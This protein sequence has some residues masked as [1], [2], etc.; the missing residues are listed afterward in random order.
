VIRRTLVSA[1]VLAALLLPAA[2]AL[3]APGSDSFFEAAPLL[4]SVPGA[5]D[6]QGY[7]TQ[8]GLEPGASPG[9]PAM[10]HTAWWRIAGTGQQIAVSTFDSNFDTVLAAYDQGDGAPGVDNRVTCDDNDASGTGSSAIAFPS[11]R[12]RS[13]LV[14]VGG[15]DLAASG[16]IVLTASAT[17]PASDDAAGAQVLQTGVPATVSNLGASHELGE[18]LSCGADVYAATTWYRFTAP[19]V[20][21]AAFSASAAF[22]TAVAVYRADSG[23]SVGCAAGAAPRAAM[24]VSAGDYLVQVATKGADFPGL[25]EGPI[26]T[27]AQFT[28]DPDLDQDGVLAPA[29]CDD[30]NPAI[31]PGALEIAGDGIDQDCNGAD[32]VIDRDRDGS[33]VFKDCNDENAKIKPGAVEIVGNGIDENCDGVVRR[34]PRLRSTIHSSFARS[35]LRFTALSVGDLVA[36]SLIRL[37][38]R[39]KGCFEQRSIAVRA[40]GGSRS[41]MRYVRSARPKRGA[42]IEIR[43]TKARKT[44]VVRRLTVRARPK[45]PRKQDLCLPFANDPPTRC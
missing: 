16:S 7:T 29:D 38:C 27:T 20:G 26:T 15:I 11:L 22:E 5:V 45:L 8:G 36:G 35:P 39:G 41:L 40:S 37:S 4:F 12:G 24:K 18:N 9:C 31:R 21:D 3:A 14:A 33:P 43:V 17:R 10:T 34:Y 28:A 13:Y 32:L 25:G 42:V 19:Q 6:D 44:G 1:G 23:R 2:P 30:H